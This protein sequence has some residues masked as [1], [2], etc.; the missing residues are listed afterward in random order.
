MCILGDALGSHEGNFFGLDV[1]G[2]DAWEGYV[3]TTE[4]DTTKEFPH[5][6]LICWQTRNP[7]MDWWAKLVV[8]IKTISA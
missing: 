4:M 1:C 6:G 7:M 5:I 8:D 3:S 2:I